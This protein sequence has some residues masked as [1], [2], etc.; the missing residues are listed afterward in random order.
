MKLLQKLLVAIAVLGLASQLVID[1]REQASVRRLVQLNATLYPALKAVTADWSDAMLQQHLHATALDLQVAERQ[2]MLQQAAYLGQFQTCR[3]I[4]EVPP[5]NPS[6]YALTGNCQFAHGTAQL[7]A[8]FVQQGDSYALY[9]LW[10]TPA[11]G[12]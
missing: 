3:N 5:A 10:F 11:A 4:I 6:L 2:Q 1:Y 8:L 7:R 12:S 9:S